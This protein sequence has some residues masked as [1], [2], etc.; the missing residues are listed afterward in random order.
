MIESEEIKK[1]LNLVRVS[2]TFFPLGSFAMSQAM[3]ELISEHIYEK[4]QLV[5][6][7]S[8]YLEKI[9][10]SFDY[11]IFMIAYEIARNNDI[12]GLIELDNICYAS[13][14]TEENRSTLTKMGKGLLSAIRLKEGAVAQNYMT[15]VNDKTAPGTFPVAIAVVSVD[16]GLGELGAI[17]LIY[18]NMM[19][20][21]A[22]LVRMGFI[23]YIDGQN[24][25]DELI[26]GIN[27]EDKSMGLNQSFPAVDI[28]SMKHELNPSRMFIS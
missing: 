19:E 11:K 24:M 7:M 15:V 5:S 22:S 1:Y 2:D 10:K 9:W 16:I 20:V 17:S 13:K 18:V 14:L 21:M 8:L 26:R 23:D 28:F 4:S 27:I 3:E 25:L 12:E 6:V